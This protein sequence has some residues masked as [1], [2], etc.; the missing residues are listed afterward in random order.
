MGSLFFLL[1]T[2]NIF[3][4][5]FILTKGGVLSNQKIKQ[6]IK[7]Y[8]ISKITNTKPGLTEGKKYTVLGWGFY[9]GAWLLITNDRGEE[10]TIRNADKYMYPVKNSEW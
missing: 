7:G 8:V 4:C 10:I 2:K 5:T 3:C 9:Q 1:L 6:K